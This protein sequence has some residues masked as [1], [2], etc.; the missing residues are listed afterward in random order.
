MQPLEIIAGTIFRHGYYVDGT[1]W[2]RSAIN[3]RCSRDPNLR[4]DLIASASI[5]GGFAGGQQRNLPQLGAAVGVKGVQAIM[6]G[7]HIQ[8]IMG[9]AAYIQEISQVKGL[10]VYF[11]VH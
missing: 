5:T 10:G 2:P 6:L 4:S 7:R 11:A 3:D 1:V 9:S 8:H